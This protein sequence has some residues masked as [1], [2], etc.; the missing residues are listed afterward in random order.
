MPQKDY[1]QHEKVCEFRIIR[2]DQCEVV[3]SNT[4]ADHNC[5]KSMAAKYENLSQKLAFVC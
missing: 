5:I 4:S 3:K 2:C 1:S